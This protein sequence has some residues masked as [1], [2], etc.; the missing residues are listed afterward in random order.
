MV[1]EA[2]AI[3]NETSV[4]S[5]GLFNRLLSGWNTS[6]RHQSPLAMLSFAVLL[7]TNFARLV[8]MTFQRDPLRAPKYGNEN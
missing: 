4:A 8:I 3:P 7:Y 5:D 6:Y 2:F 1:R